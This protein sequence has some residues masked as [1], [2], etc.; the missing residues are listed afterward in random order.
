[1]QGL[2]YTVHCKNSLRVPSATVVSPNLACIMFW[3]SD[4][5]DCLTAWS[6]HSTDVF[7]VSVTIIAIWTPYGWIV[8]LI[9]KPGNEVNSSLLQGRILTQHKIVLGSFMHALCYAFCMHG[10]EFIPWGG[11]GIQQPK[12]QLVSMAYM[13]APQHA[14]VVQ[15]KSCFPVLVISHLCLL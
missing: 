12:L 9:P 6:L 5:I 3:S 10:L 14:E 11:G 1:M 8:G 7:I 4:G 2:S 13:S 15:S